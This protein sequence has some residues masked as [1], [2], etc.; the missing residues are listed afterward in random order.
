MIKEPTSSALAYRLKNNI[1]EEQ[2]VLVFDLGRGTFDVFI[3]KVSEDACE[4]IS[5]KSDTHLGG[6]DFD[7]ELMEFCIQ[8][9]K[10]K[11]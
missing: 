11:K 7:N 10:K 2:N 4:V 1:T 8:G 6:G 9:F 5:T 3:L